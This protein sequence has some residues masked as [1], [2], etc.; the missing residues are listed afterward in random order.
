MALTEINW[1]PSR[2]DLRVFAACLLVF[3]QLAGAI[4]HWKWGG[5]Y[6]PAG[7][8]LAGGVCGIIGLLAPPAIRPVFVAM[9]VL[10]FPIGWVVSHVVLAVFFYGL[11]T[12]LGLLLRL[13][14]SDLLRR[15]F[16]PAAKSY[17]EP[18]EP[19]SDAT[20]YFRQY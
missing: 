10:A 7:I 11:L 18:H 20:R 5:T 8:A 12:P 9:V 16:D 14:G 6:L 4:L 13:F 3:A 15:K 2:R 19:S 17:W 1:Q